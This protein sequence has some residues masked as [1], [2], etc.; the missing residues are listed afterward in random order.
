MGAFTRAGGRRPGDR[1]GALMLTRR[2]LLERGARAGAAVALLL[3]ACARGELGR[4]VGERHPLAPQ[5]HARETCRATWVGR[6]APGRGARRS[7]RGRSRQSIAGGRHAFQAAGSPLH[8]LRATF[9]QRSDS[10]SPVPY[11]EFLVVLAVLVEG[12]PELL[13]GR[14]DD[15][16]RVVVGQEA[17]GR[18]EGTARQRRRRSVARCCWRNTT[19]PSGNCE[20]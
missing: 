3:A 18:S 13:D 20:R 5:P 6:G 17:T 19:C 14:H 11:E 10:A 4:N 12:E 8:R 7:S 16:V 9:V 15:L 1:E 2:E